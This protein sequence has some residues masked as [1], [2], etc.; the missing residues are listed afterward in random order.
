VTQQQRPE[1]GPREREQQRHDQPERGSPS[2]GDASNSSGGNGFRT[3]QPVGEEPLAL[4]AADVAARLRGVCAHLSE[5][6]FRTLVDAIAQVKLGWWKEGRLASGEY[7][8]LSPHLSPHLW[9]VRALPTARG[10]VPELASADAGASTG[11]PRGVG[12]AGPTV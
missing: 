2:S 6:E 7:V 5:D 10:I 8:A 1:Q 12:I 4:L 11:V 9:P 3:E